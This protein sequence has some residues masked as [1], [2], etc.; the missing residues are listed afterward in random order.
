[1]RND[2]KRP[3][4]PWSN[5]GKWD[6]TSWKDIAS[7][8]GITESYARQI[9][10]N[11]LRKMRLAMRIQALFEEGLP[12]SAIVIAAQEEGILPNASPHWIRG[13]VLGVLELDDNN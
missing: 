13:F 10:T 11:A 6:L 5:Y 8:E 7:K 9:G 12:V 2:R 4:G 1:M 3:D